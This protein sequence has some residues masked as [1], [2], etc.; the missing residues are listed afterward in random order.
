MDAVV[1]EVEAYRNELQKTMQSNCHLD[2]T[3]GQSAPQTIEGTESQIELQTDG[4]VTAAQ[5]SSAVSPE[6]KPIIDVFAWATLMV[7]F[8][9]VGII[10]G[11]YIIGPILSK[12]LG[13]FGAATLAFFVVPSYAHYSI[14]KKSGGDDGVI[15][16]EVLT[17][18][19]IQGVL[20]GFVIDSLYLSSI[21]FAVLTPAIITVSFPAVALS[22]NGNRVTQLISTIG[23]AVIFNLAVGLATN[24]LSF[25]YF[26]LS[27]T[28]GGIAAV[29]MQLFFK[30]FL[31]EAHVYQNALC[32]GFIIAKGIF[33]LLFGSYE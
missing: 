22:S 15:R 12:F 21:P 25:T 10:V 7:F 11:S 32:C 24:S 20:M 17:L 19:V 1:E 18:A 9:N 13:K 27:L 23:A 8:S 16:F 2:Q 31:R 30:N 29:V 4:L 14:K 26:L 28:Y 3:F 5:P 6:T 33:F